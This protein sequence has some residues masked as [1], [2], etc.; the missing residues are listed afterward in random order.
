MYQNIEIICISLEGLTIC[1]MT[2]FAAHQ[3]TINLD[4]GCLESDVGDYAKTV[5]G[6]GGDV[7]CLTD[8][9]R[10]VI[11]SRDKTQ[12]KLQDPDL[13]HYGV[14]AVDASNNCLA[15]GTLSGRVITIETQV[16]KT[17]VHDGKVFAITVGPVFAKLSL[18]V[19]LTS[20]FSS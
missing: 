18:P 1:D 2:I 4:D 7:F 5:I 16:K 12:L 20:L 8:R 19:R 13:C 17:Q 10:L 14:M 3:D 15:V 11:S 9:G 6:C